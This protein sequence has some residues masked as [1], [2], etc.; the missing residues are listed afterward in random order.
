MPRMSHVRHALIATLASLALVLVFIASASIDAQAPRTLQDGVFSDAQAARG[1][2]LYGQ[3]CAG[4]HGGAL[5]GGQGPALTGD[6]F[7]RKFRMEPLSAL[8]IKI[9]YTM[10]PGAAAAAQ[11][12]PEQGADLVAHVLKTNGFPAG[13]TDFPAADATTSRVSWP[14]APASE[15]TSLSAAR[16]P[17][18]GTLNQLM[19]GVF[20]PNSNLLF[21]V[22]T[23]DPAA[24]VPP[25]DPAAKGAGFS[26][27]EWGQGI[28]TGWPVI[29][30]AAAALA[31]ASPWVLT[32]G[33]RC[34]NGRLAPVTE[35]DWIRFTE[36]MASVAKRGYRLSQTKNQ[37]AVSEWTGD[38]ADACAACHSVY[39]DVG[40]RGQG[41]NPLAAGVNTARCTH[42]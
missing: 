28:Y 18:T 7:V 24:P 12:T 41:A 19:R 37:D 20:F 26:V 6:A 21:T 39:R 13:K 42:R 40:G 27:F 11:L 10:P 16:Y 1:Q 35:P 2:T 38:L 30:N 8:F 32:P 22:Q 3:R 5:A 15:A 14:P 33:L 17:P 25:P 23:R 29:E 9:R 4:C 34:E 31:D 36:Q